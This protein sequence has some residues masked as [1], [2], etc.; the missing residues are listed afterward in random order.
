MKRQCKIEKYV[1][2]SGKYILNRRIYYPSQKIDE[3]KYVFQM[4]YIIYIFKFL[5]YI[6]GMYARTHTSNIK[7][8][9]YV[10]YICKPSISLW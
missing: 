2:G 10:C 5:S 4:S 1:S 9:L 8:A 6:Q 7:Y 3:R